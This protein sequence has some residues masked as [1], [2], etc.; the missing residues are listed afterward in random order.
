MTVH[1]YSKVYKRH[2]TVC[3]RTICPGNSWVKSLSLILSCVCWH[4]A[5]F[6]PPCRSMWL[7]TLSE[8]WNVCIWRIW[9]L[10][11]CMPTWVWRRPTLWLVHVMSRGTLRW[12]M[13]RITQTGHFYPHS[14]CIVTGL[15]CGLAFPGGRIFHHY[16]GRLPP[17][18]ILL[19]TLPTDCDWVRQSQ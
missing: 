18:Q 6:H 3:H 1:R 7:S 13:Q 9:G 12:V 14:S 19:K 10:S 15:L 4:H 5:A 2:Q 11:L 16:T 17:P 8:R